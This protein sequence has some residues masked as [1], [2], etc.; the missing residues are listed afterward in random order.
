MVTEILAMIDSSQFADRI[1]GTNA[2]KEVISLAEEAE[3]HK[4]VLG[5]GVLQVLLKHIN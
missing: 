1:N 3:L 4:H 5:R 2:L